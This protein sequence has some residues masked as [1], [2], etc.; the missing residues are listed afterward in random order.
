[1]D[2]QHAIHSEVVAGRTGAHVIFVEHDPVLTMGKNADHIHVLTHKSQIQEQGIDFV[3]TD[4]GGQVT[5]HEP[6]QL[7][8]YPI[9]PVQEMGLTP[10][11]Y[12]CSLEKAVI[13]TLEDLQ[14]SSST[15]PSNPGIW[16]GANKICAVGIRIKERVSMHGIALN[17]SNNLSTFSH[18]LA[19][20]I[21][22]RGV[23]TIKQCS[24][25]T[26][27]LSLVK[28]LLAENF[29]HQIGCQALQADVSHRLQTVQ[30]APMMVADPFPE[31]DGVKPN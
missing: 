16:V 5:A 7:V 11:S 31:V 27:T 3:E 20:G 1:L 22:G 4:R 6:G 29:A 21:Q 13:K 9:L 15:D 10:R 24:E 26:P 28:S 12:V 19:C 17:V 30:E 23:T 2:L 14:I 8:M 18:I 25:V